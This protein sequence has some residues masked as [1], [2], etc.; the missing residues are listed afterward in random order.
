MEINIFKNIQLISPRIA[1]TL[2]ND[3]YILRIGLHSTQYTL[4]ERWQNAAEGAVTR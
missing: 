3:T 2:L 1:R 4:H